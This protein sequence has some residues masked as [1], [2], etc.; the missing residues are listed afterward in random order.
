VLARGHCAIKVPKLKKKKERK[1]SEEIIQKAKSCITGKIH[2]A[3]IKKIISIFLKWVWKNV[4]AG[5]IVKYIVNKLQIFMNFCIH[6]TQNMHTQKMLA[7]MS[8]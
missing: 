7:L 4:I 5:S 6:Y 8:G 1:C 3:L 2:F